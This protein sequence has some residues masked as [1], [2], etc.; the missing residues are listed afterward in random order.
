MAE[1]RVVQQVVQVAPESDHNQRVGRTVGHRT[2]VRTSS[3]DSSKLVPVDKDLDGVGWFPLVDKGSGERLE[4]LLLPARKG[5]ELLELEAVGR[6]WYF[7]SAGCTWSR[8][9]MVWQWRSL[10][11]RMSCS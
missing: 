10:V 6:V 11:V 9:A 2:K 1:V 5:R 3:L 7:R 8:I 4:M